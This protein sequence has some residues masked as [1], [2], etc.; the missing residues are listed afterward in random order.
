MSLLVC[1]GSN[2]CFKII[3]K[4]KSTKVV[5]NNEDKTIAVLSLHFVYN[6]ICSHAS[7]AVK[8]KYVHYM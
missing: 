1:F 6:P 2:L 8:T 5:H 7:K 4:S 3:W